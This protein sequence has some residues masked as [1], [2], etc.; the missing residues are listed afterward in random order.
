MGWPYQ[1]DPKNCVA[2]IKDPKDHS[3]SIVGVTKPQFGVSSLRGF[4]SLAGLGIDLT[5]KALA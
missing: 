5:D 2:K 1:Q 4:R 3:N